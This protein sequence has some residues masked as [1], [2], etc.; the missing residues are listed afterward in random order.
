MGCQVT[1]LSRHGL[2]P[3]RVP[4]WFKRLPGRGDRG[5]RVLRFAVSNRQGGGWTPD[6]APSELVGGP[7]GGRRELLCR[8]DVYLK[9]ARGPHLGRDAVPA[10]TGRGQFRLERDLFPRLRDERMR[11]RDGVLPGER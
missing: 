10:G 5:H 8:L 2:K 4:S 1:E 9:G 7:V 3:N 11:V 6:H